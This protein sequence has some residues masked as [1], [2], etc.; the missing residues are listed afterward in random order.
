[1]SVLEV[2]GRSAIAFLVL[3]LLT[4]LMGRKQISQ[5]TFF[6]YVT[7]ISIG[8]VAGDISLDHSVKLS[9]GIISLATWCGLTIIFDLIDIKS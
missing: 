6:N 9:L 8:A 2:I 5:L 4:R 1:M 7:G 3:L